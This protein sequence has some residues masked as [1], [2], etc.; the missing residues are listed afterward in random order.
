M[1][2][3]VTN[4]ESLLDGPW[5]MAARRSRARDTGTLKLSTV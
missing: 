2:T 5:K 4:E 1:A 3:V